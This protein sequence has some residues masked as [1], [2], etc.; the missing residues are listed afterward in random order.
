MQKPEDEEWTVAK[1]RMLLGRHISAMEMAGNDHKSHEAPATF[2]PNHG[3][4]QAQHSHFGKSTAGGLL[5]GN[6]HN[7]G[8]NSQKG[9]QSHQP[10]CLMNSLSIIHCRP[11]RRN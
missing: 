5:V 6:S 1:L 9:S 4:Q 11:G 8:Q 3:G 2:N 10:H 7:K